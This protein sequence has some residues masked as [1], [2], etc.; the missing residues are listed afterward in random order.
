MTGVERGSAADVKG[1][2]RGDVVVA[3]AGTAVTT[4]AEV[5]AA[6]ARAGAE[7]RAAVLLRIAR[8]DSQRLVALP[9][10]KS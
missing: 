1:L 8:R 6:I 3:V 2:R 5:A 4:P 10:P 7:G 9:L